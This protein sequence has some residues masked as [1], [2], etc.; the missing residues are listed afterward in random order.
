MKSVLSQR[1][2]C[3]QRRFMLDI[4]RGVEELDVR[5]RPS[6]R[7][8]RRSVCFVVLP[9]AQHGSVVAASPCSSFLRQRL[10]HES[11]CHWSCSCFLPSERDHC[12]TVVRSFQRCK[13]CSGSVRRI[14]I[15]SKPDATQTHVQSLWFV[16][17]ARRT[18]N[19]RR[20]LPLFDQLQV[21][22]LVNSAT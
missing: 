14:L 20:G 4:N 6:D 18:L 15:G 17:Q 19:S 10:V 1:C 11:I 22:H 2:R 13:C 16:F 8:L 7:H 3:R 9:S 12:C 21:A 5:L